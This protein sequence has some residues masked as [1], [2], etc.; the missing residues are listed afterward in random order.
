MKNKKEVN[1]NPNANKNLGL[2]IGSVIVFILIFISFIVLP[3]MVQGAGNTGIP[4]FGRWGKNAVKFEQDSFFNRCLAYYGEQMKRNSQNYNEYVMELMTRNAYQQAF[5]ETIRRYAFIDF[6]EKS[7]YTISQKKID[8]QMIPYF[9]D[10]NGKYS[11][12]IY[13]DTP[14]NKKASMRRQFEEDNLASRFLE[15]YFSKEVI[16]NETGINF[17]LDISDNEL[18]FINKMNST[19]KNFEVVSFST[20]DL[21]DS[22][23]SE[24]VNENSQ[25]FDRYFLKAISVESASA[26]KKILSQLKSSEITFED[27]VGEYSKNYYTSTN[28]DGEL[29][30]KYRYQIIETLNSSS[31]FAKIESL[32]QDS[33]SPVIKTK[34]G[35]T[36]FKC[37]QEH[38]NAKITDEQTIEDVKVYLKTNEMG[39][40]QDYFL[41]TANSFFEKAKATSFDNA[42]KNFSIY[43]KTVNNYALNFDNSSAI[44]TSDCDVE[45]LANAYKNE[46]F[47][48]KLFALK[49]NEICQPIV[50][51]DAIVVL[52][53]N[54]DKNSTVQKIEKSDCIQ[55]NFNQDYSTIYKS[56]FESKKFKDNFDATYKRN[57][58][59][60]K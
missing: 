6:V 35:F 32:E 25:M 39:R 53:A 8:R 29:K 21:P 17:A 28:G 30:N 47:L 12:K 34:T 24:Y 49:E 41:A 48:N 54:A 33:L 7:G 59:S 57:F 19:L 26:A 44:T 10:S 3:G 37:T 14:D 2:Y 52:K 50:L 38:V 23:A 5:N 43:K 45:E 55:S 31:D 16:G 56:I 1:K 36:I 60:K 58:T 40:V 4:V 15:D 22:L 18:S 42:C 46:D 27:A 20:K 9:Y 51:E 11:E 13:R